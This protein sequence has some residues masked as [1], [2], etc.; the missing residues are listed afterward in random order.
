MGDNKIKYETVTFENAFVSGF[1]RIMPFITAQGRKMLSN[2][3]TENLDPKNVIR[4]HTDSILSTVPL[5]NK[6][7]NKKDA[8]LG[9]FGYEGYYEHCVV[10]NMAKPKGDLIAPQ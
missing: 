6:Y 4:V 10:K 3:I 5:K 2:L 7:P 1:A 9:D 8:Q